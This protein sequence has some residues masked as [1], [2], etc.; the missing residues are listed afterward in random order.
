[1]FFYLLNLIIHIFIIILVLEKKNKLNFF[2]EKDYKIIV[3][4]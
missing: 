4:N 2:R 3:K 1:M